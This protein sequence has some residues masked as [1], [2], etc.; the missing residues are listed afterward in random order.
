M[1]L[2]FSWVGVFSNGQTILELGDDMWQQATIFNRASKR[3][4]EDRMQTQ[5]QVKQG[6]IRG[7]GL[8]EDSGT[9]STTTIAAAAFIHS[10]C[11]ST[12]M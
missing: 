9:S 7:R 4:E 2:I 6:K 10:V 8:Q 11:G 5:T 12:E 1:N 3:E